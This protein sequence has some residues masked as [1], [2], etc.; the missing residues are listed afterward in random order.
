MRQILWQGEATN[1]KTGKKIP[2]KI[3]GT[4]SHKTVERLRKTIAIRSLSRPPSESDSVPPVPLELDKIRGK[5]ID[6]IQA[7]LVVQLRYDGKY[8]FRNPWVQKVY[9]DAS[10]NLQDLLEPLETPIK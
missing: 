4:L 5:P 7:D 2:F 3:P 8:C 1:L 9:W 10:H 6:I